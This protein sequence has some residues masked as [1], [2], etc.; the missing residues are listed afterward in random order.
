[1]GF[2]PGYVQAIGHFS[3]PG[4]QTKGEGSPRAPTARGW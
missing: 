4:W 1:V 2:D 3:L